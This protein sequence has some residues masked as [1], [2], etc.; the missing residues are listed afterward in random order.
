MTPSHKTRP[1]L[2]A[3]LA[4]LTLNAL[5]ALGAPTLGAGSLLP[6]QVVISEIMIDPTRVSDT[7]GEWFEVHNPFSDPL[8]LQ[9][10]VVESQTGSVVERFTIGRPAPVAP[11]GYYVLGRSAAT[12]SN[13]GAKVDYP[14]GSGLSLGNS[15]DWLRISDPTGTALVQVT[16]P[17]GPA[18]R[19]LELTG[20]TLPWLTRA[21]FTPS[22]TR[23]GLGDYGTPGSANS[24]ALVL[25]GLVTPTVEAPPPAAVPEP[26]SLALL[27]AGLG[28]VAL[29][30]RPGARERERD[31]PVRARE[32]RGCR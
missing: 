20:G 31:D 10:L 27:G 15:A 26:G 11:G 23:Y 14:W 7:T 30:R 21:D 17:N 16:W 32:S 25:Q 3:A 2:A 29:R 6:G 19:S 5:P 24:N 4:S 13:G 12:G 1:A 22:L 18:G 28:A 8:D 9:G